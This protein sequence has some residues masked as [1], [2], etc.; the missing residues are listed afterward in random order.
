MGSRWSSAWTRW[1]ATCLVLCA[2]VW[3]PACDSD[4]TLGLDTPQGL[5]EATPTPSP[6]VVP[7]TPPPFSPTPT[8]APPT[9]EPGAWARA[10]SVEP[11]TVELG[12][13][14][15]GCGKVTT[16][17]VTNVGTVP[18]E[19]VNVRLL[20]KAEAWTLTVE[21]TLTTLQ[22]GDHGTITVTASADVV[23]IDALDLLV[24]APE[25]TA[26]TV[27][28]AGEVVDE[29]ESVT[30]TYY[31]EPNNNVDVLWVID[32]SGSMGDDQE[33]VAENFDAFMN[34]FVPMGIHYHMG[35]V[36][37]DM[38]SPT[39]F[40]KMQG[41][42]PGDLHYITWSMKEAGDD[43]FRKTIKTLGANGSSSERGLSAMQVALG[44]DMQAGH[45]AGFLRED[46]FLAVIFV[47][48]EEDQSPGYSAGAYYWQ[49]YL[50]FLIDLKGDISNVVCSAII[51]L[52]DTGGY[53]ELAEATGGA[54][55]EMHLDYYAALLEIGRVSA[56]FEN[57]FDL[58]AEPEPGTEITVTINGEE[59]PP[60]EDTWHYDPETGA[61][62]FSE[63]NE[64]VEGDR[65]DVTYTAPPSCEDT[66]TPERSVA[67]EG[68]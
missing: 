66:T 25:G 17:T 54:I 5:V 41:S 62:V 50:N 37:T 21:H 2:G 22:P 9:P 56:G 23:G 45:N 43:E 60:G 42:Y 11:P 51:N 58:T 52:A 24:V 34:Y 6:T 65:V 13:K 55:E 26:A 27:P 31:Q 30:D 49:D 15:L 32:N 68:R 12:R 36:T 35:V 1:V 18:V 53:P 39:Q 47:S 48:D 63:G 61:I 57:T 46:A 44:P 10:L 7:E 14:N 20:G 59:V 4:Y 8:A 28:I 33:A 38:G 29:T 67:G 40:G 16:L 19:V 64:P 3:A